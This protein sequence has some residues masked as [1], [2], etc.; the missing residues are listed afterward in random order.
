MTQKNKN[1]LLI[2][3]FALCLII[4]YQ[5]AFSKTIAIRKE[6]SN[7]KAQ[8]ASFQRFGDVSFNLG[9]RKKF[10]DSVLDKNKF[11]SISV[12]NNMLEFLNQ[13]STNEGF[14]IISFTEPHKVEENESMIT[15]YQFT[16]RG[17]FDDLVR[18]IYKI[19]QEYSFGEVSHI[20]FEKKY[21]Y[22]K[23]K[24]YLECSVI[25]KSLISE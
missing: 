4:A 1:I 10:V 24:K 6:V 12:Q 11:K 2:V 14:K 22:R 19:E 9:Q 8:T 21:D 16:I 5:L 3:G 15:S 18:V 7:L 25:I 17:N 13:E 23:R 20:N